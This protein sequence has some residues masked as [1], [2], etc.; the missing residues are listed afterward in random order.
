MDDY[1]L[2][3]IGTD[4]PALTLPAAQRVPV[5]RHKAVGG[6]KA[7]ADQCQGSLKNGVFP[8]RSKYDVGVPQRAHTTCQADYM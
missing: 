7:S 1:E 8:E 4:N 5:K 6:T 2:E 3:Q